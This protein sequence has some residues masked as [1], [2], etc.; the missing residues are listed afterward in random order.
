MAVSLTQITGPDGSP[1]TATVIN[2]VNPDPNLHIVGDFL[3]P[4]AIPV[5]SDW[6]GVLIGGTVILLLVYM[7]SNK[8]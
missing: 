1:E 8:R 5:E 7:L 4:D 6:N 2:Q 3:V